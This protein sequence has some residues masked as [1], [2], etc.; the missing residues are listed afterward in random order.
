[1]AVTIC[2]A[3]LGGVQLDKF[4][5][6]SFPLFTIFLSLVGVAAAIYF[7]VKDFLNKK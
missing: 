7:A 1:M 6:F 4:L 3:V 2:V 5:R